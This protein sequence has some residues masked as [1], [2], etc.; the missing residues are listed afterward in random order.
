MKKDIDY[1]EKEAILVMADNI[2]K[3]G[4]GMAASPGGD[5]RLASRAPSTGGD[6]VC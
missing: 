2:N 1:I 6:T 3:E 5:R 4:K